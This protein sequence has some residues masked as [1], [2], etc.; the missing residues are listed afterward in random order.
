M[1][2]SLHVNHFV[3]DLGLIDVSGD[4]IKHENIDVGFEFVRI[5]GS[6]DCFF[7]K[8]DRDLVGYELAFAR[9]FEKGFADFCA[10]ID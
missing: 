5:D 9:I 2:N 1:K 10:C 7:P 4:S 6:S 8:F 3:H